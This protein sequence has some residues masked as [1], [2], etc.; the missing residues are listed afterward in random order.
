MR[1]PPQLIALESGCDGED[2]RLWKRVR[3]LE[4]GLGYSNLTVEELPS[5]AL[6]I[7]NPLWHP[8]DRKSP[9]RKR[10]LPGVG[11]SLLFQGLVQRSIPVNNKSTSALSLSDEQS[12]PWTQLVRPRAMAGRNLPRLD[13][14]PKEGSSVEFPTESLAGAAEAWSSSE[15]REGNLPLSGASVR[16]PFQEKRPDSRCFEGDQPVDLKDPGMDAPAEN[17]RRFS[18][19]S[20]AQVKE[21]ST[22]ESINYHN[23][24]P[25]RHNQLGSSKLAPAENKSRVALD[26]A[27]IGK[28][29]EE[30]VTTGPIESN[31]PRIVVEG[32]LPSKHKFRSFRPG[33]CG[34]LLSP[35]NPLTSNTVVARVKEGLQNGGE[36]RPKVLLVG[37]GTFNP[38]HKLHIRKFYLA[39]NFLEAHKGVSW[40]SFYSFWHYE[41]VSQKP[42][43]S[44]ELYI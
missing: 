4:T 17:P 31:G 13:V 12:W 6:E 28:Q 42:Y 32:T 36:T 30:T 7:R 24:K 19:S 23:L 44:I 3:S 5:R 16:S 35:K 9:S 22:S 43:H 41:L 39:R 27:T 2:V 21:S 1:V 34:S 18:G 10:R 20:T 26:I 25:N 15:L 14:L 8:G 38:V 29:V 37:S 11:P 40:R 33:S